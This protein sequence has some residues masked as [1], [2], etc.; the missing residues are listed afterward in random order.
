MTTQEAF[1]KSWSKK[2]ER[3][4]EHDIQCGVRKAQV[5]L[6]AVPCDIRGG[7]KT[8]VDVGCG[9]GSTLSCLAAL[10]N[11]QAGLGLDY[12]GDAVKIASER[13]ATAKIRYA[14]Q[15]SLD[16]EATV[17][18]ISQFVPLPVDMIVLADVLE[19]VPD[20][21]ETITMLAPLTRY[22][23]VKIPIEASLLDNHFLP[24]KEKPGPG[25]SNG[26]LR[27]FTVDGAYAFIRQIGLSPISEGV[28]AYQIDETFPP[29]E[30]P[31]FRRWLYSTLLKNFKRVCSWVMPKRFFLRVIGGG[32]VL[33]SC[34]K[35]GGVLMGKVRGH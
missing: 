1:Y 20:P 10:L 26:H 16:I 4:I 18:Q 17:A 9:Y 15:T 14:S 22:F 31:P 19:H 25:H 27:E 28:Y 5:M 30:N 21:A 33:L 11:V 35:G 34:E 29:L 23:L 24:F 32:G 12:A 2:S 7:I 8:V 13:F 3:L 6:G